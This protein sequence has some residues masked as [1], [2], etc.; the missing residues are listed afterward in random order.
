VASDR[1]A[2]CLKAQGAAMKYPRLDWDAA[3]LLRESGKTLGQIAEE[4]GASIHTVK[5][6]SEH[7][8]TRPSSD[9]P[10]DYRRSEVLPELAAR[11]TEIPEDTRTLDERLMGS[12]LPG[13]S[14]LDQKRREGGRV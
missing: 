10:T 2:D 13:R 9:G 12:P 11:L 7:K 6:A 5:Y 8:W 14:A 4:M 1:V 3:R